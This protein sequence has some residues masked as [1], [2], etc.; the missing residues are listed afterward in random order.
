MVRWYYW[1]YLLG[2]K[3]FDSLQSR[4]IDGRNKSSYQGLYR[5][6]ND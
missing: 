4:R 5:Y 1:S 6:K 3:T 2:I